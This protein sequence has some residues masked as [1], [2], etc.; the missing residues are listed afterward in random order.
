[1]K[2]Y[3]LLTCF[4]LIAVAV[5]ACNFKKATSKQDIVC[6]KTYA[7]CTSAQCIPNP[8]NPTEAIC[9][10][11]VLEGK[12]FGH[13]ACNKRDPFIDHLGV[14]HIIST[15]SF[16]QFSTKKC[17]TCPSGKTWSDCLDQ[18]CTVDPLDSSKA[19]C[20]CKIVRTGEYQTFGGNCDSSTCDTGFWSGA[21]V[22]ANATSTKSLMKTLNL[23][24]SPTT[25][26]SE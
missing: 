1:M 12:S 21:T 25:F 24:E 4:T 17:M 20:A 2:R 10:C 23:Q 26:C 16:E 6:D 14:K 11:E 8:N 13:T 5:V 22:D 19:I 15:F 3:F 18:P 7:L 9:F